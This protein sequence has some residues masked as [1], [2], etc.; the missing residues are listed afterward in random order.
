MDNKKKRKRELSETKERKIRRSQCKYDKLA[1]AQ[2]ADALAHK[3]GMEYSA[4]ITVIEA[5]KR[6]FEAASNNKRNPKGTP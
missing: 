4:G 3:A 5:K 6:A 1:A 2:Q